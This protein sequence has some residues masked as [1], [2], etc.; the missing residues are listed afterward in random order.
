MR[1]LPLSRCDYYLYH[2]AIIAFT[3]ALMR[4]FFIIRLLIPVNVRQHRQAV[5]N[6]TV[7]S[8]ST[9]SKLSQILLLGTSP[10]IKKIVR[11]LIFY[12][13]SHVVPGLLTF[14][15]GLLT[16]K[17]HRKPN[18]FQSILSS[19]LIRLRS[20]M[21]FFWFYI[22]K[23]ILSGDVETNPGPQSKRCQEFSICHWNLNGIATHSFIKV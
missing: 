8:I 19:C 9:S 12:I 3:H 4:V 23:I 20:F 11:V 17:F 6:L 15:D 22:K 21:H 10:L 1:L 13:V 5:G 18:I 14:S 16:G 7:I 2:D